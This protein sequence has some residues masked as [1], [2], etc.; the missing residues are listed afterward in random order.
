VILIDKEVDLGGNSA[1]A[2]S[3]INGCPTKVQKKLGISDSPERFYTDTMVA[4][5]R[6]NDPFLV[7][8]LVHESASAVNFLIENGVDLADVNLCG[9]H[10]MPRTHW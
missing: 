6:E 4:G 10:S 7:D 3:G 2:S 9:G 5:D 1:K 8:I